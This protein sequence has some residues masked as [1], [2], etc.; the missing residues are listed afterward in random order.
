MTE[1]G[2][3]LAAAALDPLA[4]GR[5]FESSRTIRLG[6]VDTT[7][8]LRLDGLA[9]YLQDVATD[10]T[11]D[12]GIS[13]RRTSW[14]VRRTAVRAERWPSYLERVTLATFCSGI[15]PRW[16]ERR[17]SVRGVERARVDAVSL[18]ACID[19]ATGR[20]TGLPDRFDAVW[21]ATAAGRTVS[22]RLLHPPVPDV[23]GRPWQVRAA[24]LD[25]LGHVNNAV[26]WAAIEDE[27]T[28]LL[29]GAVSVEAECEYR[30]PM[31]LG[32]DVRLRS[33]VEGCVLRTWITGEL[34]LC[35]SAVVRTEPCQISSR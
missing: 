15:G 35:A 12:A 8:R 27:L 9:E 17:T 24:D 22:A 34:G 29:P 13:D 19:T 5:V 16:A 20:A 31:E 23:P 33:V 1:H 18:W 11:R 10:D 14:V 7:G 6:D 26:H 2:G 32:D 30:V 4:P 3:V 28:R 21:G 25:V